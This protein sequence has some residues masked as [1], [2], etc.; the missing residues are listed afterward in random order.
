MSETATGSER[1]VAQQKIKCTTAAS[2]AVPH[3]GTNVLI[4][5][6]GVNTTQELI[7]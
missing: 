1:F 7:F 5:R 4:Q 6:L 2:A 3:Y